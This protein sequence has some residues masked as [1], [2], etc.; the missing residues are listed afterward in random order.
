MRI[1]ADQSLLGAL[2]VEADPAFNPGKAP[3]LGRHRDPLIFGV[4]AARQARLARVERYGRMTARRGVA[5]QWK[6][7]DP[8][9]VGDV[10]DPD[11]A[12]DRRNRSGRPPAPA[13][14]QPG[15]PAGPPYAAR[16]RP[17]RKPT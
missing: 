2:A 4:A 8:A 17:H 9:A 16:S 10:L 7:P 12:R 14:G 13:P 15:G 1:R 6:R 3:A 5:A 11:E